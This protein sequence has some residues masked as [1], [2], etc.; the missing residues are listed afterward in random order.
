MSIAIIGIAAALAV[1][2]V[3]FRVAH[4]SAAKIS[5][6]DALRGYTQKVDL[7]AFLNLVDPS[8]E[9]FL[10]ANL[11]PQVFRGV[12]RQR[13]LAAVEYVRAAAQDA[14]VLVRLGEVVSADENPQVFLIGQELV[15]AAIRLRAF[16]FF[17]L[18]LLYVKVAIPNSRLSVVQIPR[19]YE[20]LIDQVGCLARLKRPDRTAHI[21]QA[22]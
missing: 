16:S 9:E 20:R 12:Q 10:R 17:A 3:S 4:G 1:A 22:L 15:T 18:C 14:A 19:S 21:L 2:I 11:A 6:I 7:L 5:S 13:L 8:E